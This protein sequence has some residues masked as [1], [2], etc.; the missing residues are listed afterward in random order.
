MINLI[1]AP[2]FFSL[3]LV[4][5]RL[6]TNKVSPLIGNMLFPLAAFIVQSIVFLYFKLHGDK[7]IITK[8][9]LIYS[10]VGGIFLGLYTIFLFQ[11]FAYAGISKASPI[12]Y[13]TAIVLASLFG[14]LFLKENASPINIFGMVLACIGLA[15]VYLK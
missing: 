10:G 12:V 13:I 7:F 2:L 9:G 4:F 8:Q 3:T 1:L 11:A 14:I 15:L 6:S 5:I